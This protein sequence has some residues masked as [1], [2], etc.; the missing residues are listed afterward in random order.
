MYFR[1]LKKAHYSVHVRDPLFGSPVHGKV[2]VVDRKKALIWSLS[3]IISVPF[4]M[5]P[6]CSVTYS[7]GGVRMR[8]DLHGYYERSLAQIHG[9]VLGG[10]NF[11][12]FYQA[13][14]PSTNLF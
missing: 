14:A 11:P 5:L 10:R 6:C 8:S 13:G 7:T 2:P 1:S 9:Q 4:L 3:N 12:W